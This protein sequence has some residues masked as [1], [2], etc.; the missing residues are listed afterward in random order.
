MYSVQCT[1]YSVQCTVDT[2]DRTEYNIWSCKDVDR[3]GEQRPGSEH[4]TEQK[5]GNAKH[6]KKITVHA[7]YVLQ[8]IRIEEKITF[9]LRLNYNFL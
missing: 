8:H 2:A 1:V 4:C 6:K 7:H 5:A 9:T 3:W